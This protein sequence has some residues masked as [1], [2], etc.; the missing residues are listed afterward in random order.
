MTNLGYKRKIKSLWG[1]MCM[2]RV[3]NQYLYFAYP[4]DAFCSL[5]TLTRGHSVS[6]SGS[7]WSVKLRSDGQEEFMKRISPRHTP[8]NL[9]PIELAYTKPPSSI[10]GGTGHKLAAIMQFALWL[11]TF[12]D[13][14]NVLLSVQ[15]S[16]SSKG[17]SQLYLPALRIHFDD[18]FWK[19][20]SLMLLMPLKHR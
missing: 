5:S 4:A 3:H 17:V 16:H 8:P 1:L 12:L 20:K 11:Y 6:I 9:F 15:F 2:W 14:Q 18:W 13:E 19:F 10:S 7:S